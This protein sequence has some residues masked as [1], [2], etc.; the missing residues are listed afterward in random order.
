M[1]NVKDIISLMPSV[2][3]QEGVE[4]IKKAYAFAENAH[5]EDDRLSGE[6][7]MIHLQ[8]TAG[9]LAELGLGPRAIS[10]GLLHDVME[11]GRAG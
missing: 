3:S 11:D 9:T 1:L 8:S 6:T 4:L 5:Q 2:P 7:Y 10:A